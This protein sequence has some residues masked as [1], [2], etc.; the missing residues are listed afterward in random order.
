MHIPFRIYA[1]IMILPHPFCNL[2]SQGWVGSAIVMFFFNDFFPY[3]FSQFYRRKIGNE[4][5][6]F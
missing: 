2:I 6:Y 4:F 1:D 5:L 3:G